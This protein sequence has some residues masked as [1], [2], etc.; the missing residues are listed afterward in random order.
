MAI[1]FNALVFKAQKSHGHAR[2]FQI[3]SGAMIIRRVIGGF[4]HNE[5]RWNFRQSHKLARGLGLQ[6]TSDEI[7]P[8]RLILL[9]RFQIF[10]LLCRGI[11]GQRNICQ[12]P[13]PCLCCRGD[14]IFKR[15]AGGLDGENAFHQ[16]RA[17][18]SHDPAE[19]AA[20]RMGNEN[21]RARAVEQGGTCCHHA[22]LRFNVAGQRL[23]LACKEL[24]EDRIAHATLLLTRARPL[25]VFLSLRPCFVKFG[26]GELAFNRL[27]GEST[28]SAINIRMPSRATTRRLVDHINGIALF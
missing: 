23:H 8:I 10:R 24:V 2:L 27:R 22:L 19:H 3:S 28:Q 9:H 13:G 18:F 21:G 11:I 25:R 17:R 1:A 26:R 14:G 5:E 15:R 4:R 12:A 20:L 16:F 7:S 6:G